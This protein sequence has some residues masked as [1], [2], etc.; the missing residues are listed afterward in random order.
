[1]KLEG[2]PGVLVAQVGPDSPF[3]NPD[4]S[5]LREQSLAGMPMNEVRRVTVRQE[6]DRVA[7]EKEGDEHWWIT[8]PH[9]L[10]ASQAVMTA[11]LEAVGNAEVVG[12][13]DGAEPTGP[14]FRLGDSSMVVGLAGAGT[15]VEIRLGAGTDAGVRFAVRTGRDAIMA[16]SGER[17]FDLPVQVDAFLDSKVTKANRYKVRW[18]R[19]ETGGRTLELSRE[20]EREVWVDPGG[21]ELEDAAVFSMLVRLLEGRLLE[22]RGGTAPALPEAVLEYEQDDGV[23]DRLMFGPDGDV[24]LESVP[25][26]VFTAQVRL[27][28]IPG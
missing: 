4:P 12:F 11:F 22:W 1:M 24:A 18:F 8:A 9:R 2:R 21:G 28:E 14:E 20:A 15:E 19:Y 17:L 10:P 27:P 5:R 7:L 13:V 23:K 25:G 6:G 16:V 26:V 3:L